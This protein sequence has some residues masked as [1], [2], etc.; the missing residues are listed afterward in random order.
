MFARKEFRHDIEKQEGMKDNATLVPMLT[1]R[2]VAK[3]L[4]VHSN[5]V[6]RW[7]DQGIL[8]AY[9]ISPRGDR[10]YRREDIE[11]FLTE[12]NGNKV[13]LGRKK[14]RQPESY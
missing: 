1:V 11:Y 3:L 6:R 10:R 13:R 7:S 9:R 2:Q 8:R 12:T 14:V 5:T 4:H